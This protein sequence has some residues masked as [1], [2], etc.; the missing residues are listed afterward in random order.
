MRKKYVDGQ[1]R[2]HLPDNPYKSKLTAL[3]FD[4]FVVKQSRAGFGG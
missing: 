1:G 4:P 2:I 3:I